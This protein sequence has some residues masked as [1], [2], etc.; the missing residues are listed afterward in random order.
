[1][2]ATE[3]TTIN[4]AKIETAEITRLQMI[5][6]IRRFVQHPS[7]SDLAKSFAHE[8]QIDTLPLKEQLAAIKHFSNTH[9]DFRGGRERW[10]ARKAELTIEQNDAI[11]QTA[12]QLG[13]TEAIKPR[14]NQYDA[15]VILGAMGMH[16]LWRTEYARD[17]GATAPLIVSLGTENPLPH[18]APTQTARQEY[19]PDAKIEFDLMT[20]AVK[21]VYG[22]E[23][24]EI[25]FFDR[26][27]EWK[28]Q[29]HKGSATDEHPDIF[30]LS[31]PNSNPLH[32][33]R[34]NTANTYEFLG[35]LLSPEDQNLLIITSSNFQ[36]FQHFDALRMLAI[37][38]GKNV[39]TIGFDTRRTMYH[40]PQYYLQEMNSAINSAAALY[41]AISPSTSR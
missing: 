38:Y 37:P 9:W 12:N 20:A 16:P 6:E 39:E 8:P 14:Q 31:A 7:L 36:P 29:H 27:R 40:E 24:G 25:K 34:A 26:F 22:R 11:M 32:R 4:Q 28:I 10:E 41:N 18:S 33:S 13:M 17:C 1:M 3:N 5:E 35:T 2:A 30:V 23:T 15:I 21:K 19:A